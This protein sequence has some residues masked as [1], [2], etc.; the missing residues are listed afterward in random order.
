[1]RLQNM[2]RRRLFPA[3][4]AAFV[5]PIKLIELSGGSAASFPIRPTRSVDKLGPKIEMPLVI[6]A[7]VRNLRSRRHGS[8]SV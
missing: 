3:P 2:I 8:Q 1:M 6:H 4:L 5:S 7:P